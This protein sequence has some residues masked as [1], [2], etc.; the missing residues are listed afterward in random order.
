VDL[1]ELNRRLGAALQGGPPLVVSDTPP[2]PGT[3]WPDG[4]ALVLSTS[5]STGPPQL[6]ALSAD[7]VKASARLSAERL[8]GSGSWLL[9]LPWNHAAGLNVLARAY[10]AQRPVTPL[11]PGPFG[12]S[13]LAQALATMDPGPRYISLVPTQLARL[14][15]AG[16]GGIGLLRGFEA[17]LVGGAKLDPKMLE[18]FQNQDVRLVET[19][20]MAETCGGCVY[21][22]RPLDG[23]EIA[24]GPGQRVELAG[25]TLAL[26]YIGGEPVSSPS[27]FFQQGSQRWFASSDRGHFT[28]NGTLVV[29]GRLDH[30]ITTGGFTVAPERIETVLRSVPGVVDA[31]VVGLPHAHWG[32]EVVALVVAPAWASNDAP[33]LL[34]ALREAAKTQ[35]EPAAAPH[36]TALV[37]KLPV[38]PSQKPDRRAALD[39]AARLMPPGDHANQKGNKVKHHG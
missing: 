15:A 6:V 18:T 4:T 33:T 20:G 36:R 2:T 26:G 27:R 9:A 7:A 17:V 31:L 32:Q 21:N 34:P 29:E 3:R 22:G 19:Y 35:L 23:V 39:L 25:P 13:S 5:G 16:P 10:W 24:L 38:L 14:A 28:T 30:A 11:P 12:A 37:E 8:G 1:P